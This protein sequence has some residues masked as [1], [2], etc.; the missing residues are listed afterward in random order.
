M[1]IPTGTATYGSRSDRI[2]WPRIRCCACAVLRA[3]AN[4]G[5]GQTVLLDVASTSVTGPPLVTTYQVNSTAATVATVPA[6][7][8]NADAI[9][10][11][12]TQ[13]SGL[14]H[15]RHERQQPDVDP[16]PPQHPLRCDPDHDPERS[17]RTG[18]HLPGHAD[19]HGDRQ[20]PH[21][22]R[23][24]LESETNSARA[25]SCGSAAISSTAAARVDRRRNRRPA[26]KPA[27][28]GSAK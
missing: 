2:R 14:A 19:G 13:T 12:P 26:V 16:G 17:H 25:R 28:P 18:D 4:V 20:Q 5:V 1:V 22:Q 10:L 3:V 27:F 23:S 15:L 7:T 9:L 8:L 21:H 11:V 6:N 24:G